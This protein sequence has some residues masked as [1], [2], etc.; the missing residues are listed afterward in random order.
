MGNI[1]AEISYGEKGGDS[2]NA[3]KVGFRPLVNVTMNSPCQ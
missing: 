2:K 1:A 3:T